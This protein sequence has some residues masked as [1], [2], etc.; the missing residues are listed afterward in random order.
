MAHMLG[1]PAQ[2]GDR[3]RGWI[4]DILELGITDEAV[5]QR[6]TDEMTDYFSEQAD[7][8]YLLAA[9]INGNPLIHNHFFGTLRLLLVA[10]IDTTWSAIGSCLW[11][12]ATHDD[13]RRRLVAEPDL[14]PVAVEEFL[15]AY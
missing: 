3:F 11:H 12:L 13:D 15:R 8:R 4:H 1:I 7:K 10:G 2:D 14:L 9:R 5:T 6:A